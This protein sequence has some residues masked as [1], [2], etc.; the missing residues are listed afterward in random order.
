ME[1]KKLGRCSGLIYLTSNRTTLLNFLKSQAEDEAA[2]RIA[3]WLPSSVPF[4]AANSSELVDFVPKF[5]HALCRED[6][7]RLVA[8]FGGRDSSGQKAL[9]RRFTADS[10]CRVVRGKCGARQS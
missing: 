6:D 5:Q 3:H 9:K 2:A 1:L 7:G 4:W 8:C 10:V